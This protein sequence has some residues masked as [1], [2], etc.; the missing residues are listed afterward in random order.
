MLRESHAVIPPIGS[1]EDTGQIFDLLV[2]KKCGSILQFITSMIVEDVYVL[3]L[4]KY[5]KAHVY[6]NPVTLDLWSALGR[7]SKFRL[8]RVD[9]AVD[10]NS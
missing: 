10:R 3:S 8:D 5:L 9:D 7:T 1:E 6:Q 4:S 2:Y